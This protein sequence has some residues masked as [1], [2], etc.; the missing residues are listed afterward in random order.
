MTNASAILTAGTW[1]YGACP[2]VDECALDLDDCSAH[3]QCRNTNTSFVCEC[4]PGFTVAPGAPADRSGTVDAPC[5][6][7]CP[8]GCVH[9][10]CTA[11]SVCE[12]AVGY[13]G[14]NC[15]VDCGCNGNAVCVSDQPEDRGVCEAC[16]FNTTGTL[17]DR[18]LPGFFGDA[19]APQGCRPCACNGHGD[20]SQ[21]T[22]DRETGECF[23]QHYTIGADCSACAPGFYGDPQ[24]GAPCFADCDFDRI[25][26][27]D[28]SW[29]SRA[30]L[31]EPLGGI[32]TNTARYASH[33]SEMTCLWLLRG[34]PNSTITL[35]FDL[36]AT[37][38]TYDYVHVF[39]GASPVASGVRQLGA[40]TG[41][42]ALP[43]FVS[44][45]G[46]MLVSLYADTNFELSGFEARYTIEACPQACSDHG[47]CGADGACSCDPGWAGDDCS[48][49]FCPD[50]C[51]ADRGRG[52]CVSSS[53]VCA[54]RAGLLGASC[55]ET[56]AVGVWAPYGDTGS[57]PPRSGHGAVLV[58][59]GARIG[60]T[61]VAVAHVVLF[62]GY[63][64]NHYSND[65]WAL[66]VVD[67]DTATADAP[68]AAWVS[69]GGGSGDEG[70]T[71]P[72]GRHLHS[73]SFHAASGSIFVYGGAPAPSAY[74]AELWRF[75]LDTLSWTRLPS[76][77]DS[78]ACTSAAHAAQ[79]PAMAGHAA[80]LVNDT[81]YVH[82]GVT[83]A[84]SFQAR[85]YTYSITTGCWTA[86]PT[87][88][89]QPDGAFGHSLTYD[90]AREQLV[91]FGGKR[92]PRTSSGAY[93]VD[94]SSMVR[95]LDLAT[96]WWTAMAAH[97]SFC[98]RQD[99]DCTA[100]VQHAAAVVGDYLL[101]FGGSPFEHT[102]TDTCFADDMLVLHI[103]C[104]VWLPDVGTALATQATTPYRRMAHS[105]HALLPAI[106]TGGIAGQADESEG[107]N[108]QT[109]SHHR[110]TNTGG[111][112]LVVA[113]FAGFPL[114][115]VG[116]IAL[117][118]NFC[119]LH[120]AADTC[121][122]DP[123]CTWA[124][125]TCTA[126]VNGTAECKALSCAN[127]SPSFALPLQDLCDLCVSD[128]GCQQCDS[129][130]STRCVEKETSCAG[131]VTESD[132]ERLGNACGQ[133]DIF[134]ACADCTQ[135]DAGCAWDTGTGRCVS[136]DV[137]SRSV[138]RT[139]D[140]C[141]A[142]CAAETTCGGCEG[143]GG[144]FWC[145]STAQCMDS[146]T[147]VTE[148]AFGQC[149][150]Y[151]GM[152]DAC[153]ALN[154]SVFTECSDCLSESRCGWCASPGGTGKGLCELGTAVGPG[155]WQPATG[156]AC[157]GLVDELLVSDAADTEG[158]ASNSST[159]TTDAPA[160]TSK[161]SSN[162]TH[163]GD[164]AWAYFVCP[165]VDECA[166]GLDE[167]VGLATCVNVDPRGDPLTPSYYCQCPDNYRL[168]EDGVS[169][170][171][172]CDRVG[173]VHGYCAEP[174]VC[175]CAPGW[176]GANCSLDCGCNGHCSCTD[177]SNRTAC[178]DNT[179]GPDCGE[180]LAG[181][182]GHA[183]DN[184]TC[185]TCAQ[186]CNN[187][188]AVCLGGARPGEGRCMGCADDT[189]GDRCEQCAPGFFQSPRLLK[190][191]AAEGQHV[192]PYLAAQPFVFSECV[193]CDCNGHGDMCDVWT[194]EDCNCRDNTLT[195]R[196]D[197]DVATYGTCWKA[198]CAE[199]EAQIVLNNLRFELRGEPAD[200]RYCYAALSNG[201]MVQ[202]RIRGG[203]T[204]NFEVTAGI[205]NVDMRLYFQRDE[206]RAGPL[207][208]LLTTTN[209]VTIDSKGTVVT[210]GLLL[211][212]RRL[213]DQTIL[214]LD[215]KRYNF[216][217]DR[218]HIVLHNPA[219][220]TAEFSF[221]YD[222]QLVGINL[223]VFFSVF[224]SAF[225]LFFALVVL[226][227]KFR[228][229]YERAVH[230]QQE[231][232]QLE[233]RLVRD[234]NASSGKKW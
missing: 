181:Y 1:H 210:S 117:P 217:R 112:L 150:R 220:A 51:G 164:V 56:A 7:V 49:P 121:G 65:V 209:N 106:G 17:C 191:A 146:A 170:E 126:R 219:A 199:C 228:A 130:F 59:A 171:A 218:F 184:G 213:H 50:D 20:A 102:R 233:V 91:L 92:R 36:F 215:S 160:L 149:F 134:T 214:V 97:P 158:V 201:V 44:T 16:L 21:G 55:N 63:D 48:R 231:Q 176:Y 6:P 211:E 125:A 208:I 205:T 114:G 167:C 87:A 182:F 46:E 109:E 154:C 144:C 197:C 53:G 77:S 142:P 229:D 200:G 157:A 25:E 45:T 221:V 70:V 155:L 42:A 137:G 94:R 13:A 2:D 72:T 193:P 24:N 173:C 168:A 226:F 108:N 100:R 62:G 206:A 81:L 88:G 3:A 32:G 192:Q 207:R 29:S 186:L 147:Y 175:L 216:L 138:L 75:S 82:G 132:P 86:P 68:A 67:S 60:D 9:G 189:V 139:P 90:P 234:R 96:G 165:D 10:E 38:C 204:A 188:S 148:Y 161:L 74:S 227:A 26:A 178:R 34:P 183:V 39:D 190:A 95:T 54:C 166:Q 156:S 47:H 136:A 225:F 105:L 5:L 135:P 113:G 83:E 128:D 35:R 177:P 172:V 73:A 31:T 174:D 118:P 37:E 64:L 33:F 224:F 196:S 162:A 27:G 80:A 66:P 30:Y 23:C 163:T 185:L 61:R 79:P 203:D 119:N 57:L 19:T 122:E 41:R 98:P 99:A 151:G 143:R 103:P 11:P 202:G 152:K 180:C 187:H 140:Q 223:F 123:V 71:W 194:G 22:C 120:T 230:S 101:V 110:Q 212:D 116:Q 169:C 69:L 141:A 52:T 179:A 4:Q 85:V 89:A 107:D 76:N 115:D 40:I 18:C 15:T 127:R 93:F 222:Q 12:C 232:M 84:R 8:Q 28:A 104:G 78:I 129:L 195:D 159:T 133:C 145:E 198:Q 14:A 124:N 111:R 58:P 43:A 131:R 153:P